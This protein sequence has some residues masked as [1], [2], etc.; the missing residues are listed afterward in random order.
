MNISQAFKH[1]LRRTSADGSMDPEARAAAETVSAYLSG[2][3]RSGDAEIFEDAVAVV[4]LKVTSGAIGRWNPDETDDPEGRERAARAYLQTMYV[5]AKRDLIRRRERAKARE[6]AKAQAAEASTAP[7]AELDPRVLEA[8]V[9]QVV[10]R[11]C[12]GLSDEHAARLRADA[13]EVLEVMLGETTLLSLS[14]AE[15]TRDTK[16]EQLRQRHYR[17]RRMMVQAAQLL[18][19]REGSDPDMLDLLGAVLRTRTVSRGSK[20]RGES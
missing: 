19:S 5:N 14:G 7:E 12:V 20:K 4:L 15:S 16:Y 6:A 13:D 17:A 3:R 2:L 1:F 8:L 9:S 18:R 11:A 10:D